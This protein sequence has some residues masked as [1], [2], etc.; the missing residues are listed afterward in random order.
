MSARHSSQT[1][2]ALL[3]TFASGTFVGA[4][5]RQPRAESQGRGPW[6]IEAGGGSAERVAW[7][8]LLGREM[9][10]EHGA[11]EAFFERHQFTLDDEL[12]PE[13][14]FLDVWDLLRSFGRPTTIFRAIE[15][16]P[17]S[18]STWELVYSDLEIVSRDVDG[19][20]LRVSELRFLCSYDQ[21]DAVE[22]E[23]AT[24]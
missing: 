22:Y 17:Q 20:I 8:E 23:A 19:D 18:G 1:S 16:V 21:L 4:A 5:Q 14:Y 6:S 7:T 2:L 15:D 12:S 9:P 3:L 13:L 10:T 24:D 11:L